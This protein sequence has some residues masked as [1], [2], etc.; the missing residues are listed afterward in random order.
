MIS[1][2]ADWDGLNTAIAATGADRVLATH[3]YT[4]V[5]SRWLR[6]QGYDAGILETE[7]S[8]DTEDTDNAA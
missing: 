2:H 1:D 5:L 3:G 7:F 4:E 8:G 6:D